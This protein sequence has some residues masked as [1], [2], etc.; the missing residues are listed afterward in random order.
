MMDHLAFDPAIPA[1]SLTSIYGEGWHIHTSRDT[2]ALVEAEG[3]EAMGSLLLAVFE[4]FE[5]QSH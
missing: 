5:S 2:F 3:L 1:V 4:S